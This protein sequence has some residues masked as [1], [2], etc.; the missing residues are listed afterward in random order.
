MKVAVIGA[1]GQLGSDIVEYFSDKCT[2]TSLNHSDI[3]ITDFENSKEVLTGFNPDIVINTAA[4]HVV[5][6]CEEEPLQA[7]AING[8]GPLNLAKL[9]ETL[10]FKLAHFSTDYVFDG[11]KGKPYVETDCPNPLNVY[12]QTKL[13]GENLIRNYCDTHFVIRV[14]GIYGKTPCRAKGG[15]FI[16]TMRKAAA[17]RQ[18]VKVVNDEVL[19][20]TPTTEIAR[21]TYELLQTDAYG[22]YHMTSQQEVS[23]YEFAKVIFRELGLTTPLESCTVDDFPSPVK[24]PTYSA[25]E[26]NNLKKINLD[27]MSHWEK[28]LINYLKQSSN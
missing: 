10:G 2:V 4:Y 22:L 12:A 13:D 5:P 8:N 26:N 20:P 28:A 18:I 6:K 23:W 16:D 3:E 9:S 11:A 19:T 24:R 17:S 25:L 21:N 7:F 1:N 27:L 14:A 15:N